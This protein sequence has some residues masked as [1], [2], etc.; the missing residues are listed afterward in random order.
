[1]NR[2][3]KSAVLLACV[4]AASLVFAALVLNVARL[5]SAVSREVQ[6][7]QNAYMRHTDSGE[8]AEHN[9]MLL[10]HCLRKEM[11]RS[12]RAG[13]F[14]P[15]AWAVSARIRAL[16]GCTRSFPPFRRRIRP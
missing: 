13:L 2:S 3:R 10:G 9:A 5:G 12:A 4:A 11:L 1:M 7:A 14:D 8:P 6:R 16:P 15:D